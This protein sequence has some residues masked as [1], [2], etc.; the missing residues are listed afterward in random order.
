MRPAR[1]LFVSSSRITPSAA[2]R[3]AKGSLLPVGFSPIRQK[4]ASVSILSASAT[5][6]E[7]GSVGT[8]SEG[9]SGW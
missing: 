2:R 4:P 5:A 6:T 3:R 9:P 7:T 8:A 1:E